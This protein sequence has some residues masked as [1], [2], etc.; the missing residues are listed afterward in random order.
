VYVWSGHVYGLIVLRVWVSFASSV[1]LA[2]IV[3]LS[4]LPLFPSLWFHSVAS[5]S[6][7]AALGPAVALLENFFLKTGTWG[8]HRCF[9]C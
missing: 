7:S 6:A 5:A 1:A 9:F 3:W 2:V 4:L 8:W